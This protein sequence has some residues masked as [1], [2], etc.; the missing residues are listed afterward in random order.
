ME[1]LLHLILADGSGLSLSLSL[2]HMHTHTHTQP[3][4]MEYLLNLI[5][6]IEKTN[7]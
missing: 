7:L 4:E 5:I 3:I 6:M 2:T 1:Y